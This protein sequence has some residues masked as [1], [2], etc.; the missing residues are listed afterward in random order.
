VASTTV[1]LAQALTSFRD[2]LAIAQRL[3]QAD[4][5]NAGWQRD[6]A[7]SHAKL[8]NAYRV[9][10]DIEAARHHLVAGR[11]I[12]AELV[13]KFPDWAQWRG[14]LARFDRLLEQL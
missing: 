1:H 14:D 11:A 10:R 13:G 2:G 7:V 12:M 8:A 9:A 6:V 5:G 4:P 3:A